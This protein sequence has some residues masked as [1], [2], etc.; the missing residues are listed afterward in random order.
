[1]TSQILR[2]KWS[3]SL[4]GFLLSF[5]LLT[6]S[7]QAF[8]QTPIYSRN[9]GGSWTTGTNWSLTGHGGG[10]CGCTPGASNDVLIGSDDIVVI[11]SG[12]T[13]TVNSITV[14]DD[15][16]TATLT[17]GNT[18]NTSITLTVGNFTI[19]AG[20]VVQV[21]GDN[22]ATHAVSITGNFVNN[23]TFNMIPATTDRANVTID[24]AATKT[25]SGTGTTT[26]NNFTIGAAGPDINVS[27]DLNINGILNWSGDGL[28]ILGT[29]GDVILGS[30]ATMTNFNSNR[31]IQLDGLGTNSESRLIK[32]STN[33]VNSWRILY[34]VGTNTGGYT[35][36]DFSSSTMAGGLTNNSTLSVKPL[37]NP[38]TQGQMRR[39]FKIVVAGNVAA[40]TLT[41][42]NFYY[43]TATDLSAGD[44]QANYNTTWFLSTAAGGWATVGGTAPGT[45]FFTAPGSAQSLTTGTYFYAIGNAAGFTN[46]W[47]SYQTGVWND[48]EIWTLDPSGTTFVNPTNTT[49]LSGDAVVILNGFTVT[50]NVSGLTLSSTTIQGGAI[51]DIATSTGHNLGNVSGSGLLRVKSSSLP[52]GTY[53]AFVAATGGTIEY[54]DVGGTLT[55]QATYNKLIFSNST[56]SDITYVTANNFSVN[57][58]MQIT[59]TGSGNVTWQIN[60]NNNTP[61][62]IVINGDLTVDA[63]GRI[64]AGTGNAGNNPHALTLKGN[65]TNNGIVKFFDPTDTDYQD[66]DYAA[67]TTWTQAIAGNTV[68]VTFSGV[69]NNTVSCNNTT[70][71]YRLIVNK[72]TGQ[73]AILTVNSTATAN[74]RLFAPNDLGSSGTAPNSYSNNSLS[75]INGTLQLTGNINITNMVQGGGSYPLPQNGCI[76]LNGSVTVQVTSN[77]TAGGGNSRMMIV[78]GRLRTSN[79]G[80]VFNSGYSRGLLGGQSGELIVEDGTINTYQFRTTNLGSGNNFT[81]TQSGGTV[82]VG[83]TGLTGE[84]VNDYPRFALPYSTTSFTMTNGTLN[85]GNPMV[86]GVSAGGGIMINSASSAINVTGGTV[87]VFLPNTATNFIICSNAPFYNFRVNKTGAGASVASIAAIAATDGTTINM[88]AQPLIVRNNLTLVSGNSPTL[89]CNN[90]NVTIGGHFEIQTGTTFTPGTNTLTFNGSADQTWTNSGTITSLNNVVMT[91]TGTLQMAGTGFP[92]MVGLALNSGTLHDGGNSWNVTSTISNSAVHSGTGILTVAG[93]TVMGGSNGTFGNLT[94]TTNGAVATSG[95]QTVTGDLRLQGGNSTLNISLYNLTVYGGI[96]SNSLTSVAFTATK[97]ILTNGARNDGGLTRSGVVGQTLLFP[98][99]TSAVSYSPMSVRIDAATTVGTITIRPVKTVHPN[100][101]TANQ[102]M[103]YFWRVNSTGF[104][105]LTGVSHRAY[106]YN[107]ATL[108][109]A[110]ANYRIARYDQTTFSWSYSNAS[111]DAAAVTVMPDFSTGTGWTGISSD[112]LDGEYTAGNTSAFG[113]VT[114]YYTRVASGNW[115]APATWS[116]T[117]INGPASSTAPCS[118]CPVVIGDATNN[119]TVLITADNQSCGSLSVATNSVLDCGTFTGLNFGTSAPIGGNGRIRI[120]SANFPGGDFINFLGVAGGTIEWYGPGYTIPSTGP[121]PASMSLSNYYNL[122][123]SP[124]GGSTILMPAT[125]LT[126]HNNLTISGASATAQ[127]NSNT[128]AA[129]SITVKNDFSVNS[130]VFTIRNGVIA[131]YVVNGNTTVAS[132]ASLSVQNGGATRTHTFTTPGNFTNNGTVLFRGGNEL[133][134]LTFTGTANT[135]LTGTNAG[136]ST[137]LNTVTVNKG[138]SQASTLTIDVAGTVSTLSNNWLTLTNG[139]VD[140]NRSGGTFVLTNTATNPYTIPATAKL[141]VRNGTVTVSNINNDNSDLLL[142]GAIEV[143]G[144]TLNIGAS[145]N[146]NN[147]DIEYASAGT[148]TITVSSGTLYVNGSIRRPVTT[149]AGALNYDQSGGDVTVGGRNANN[150]RGVFEIENSTGSDFTLTGT[151]TLSV[152][153]PTGGSLFTDLYLNPASNAVSST[154]TVY[155]GIAGTTQT[156]DINVV[157]SLGNLFV[158]NNTTASMQSSTLTTTGTLTINTNTA[159]LLTNS[160]DVTIGGDLSINGTGVYNGTVGSGNTTIFNGTGAQSATLSSGST[161]LNM[162][163]NKPSGTVSLSGTSPTITNLNILSGILDVNSLNLSVIGDIVNNSSQVNTGG[164]GSISLAGGAGVTAQS[165]TSNG[166]SFGNLTLTGSATAKTVTVSG[167]VTI[168]GTLNFATTNRILAVG[169]SLV[170]FGNASGVTG[171]GGTSFIR[172]NGVSSDLGVVKRWAVGTSTF[173]YPVGT[174]TNYTPVTMTLTVTTAGDMTVVPVD[175]RHPTANTGSLEQIL[176]YYWVI[177]RT[178]S[179]AYSTT[180]SHVYAFPSALMGGAGGTV[181]AGY[182]D[183]ASTTPGWITTGHGGTATTSSMTYTNLLNTNL[184][185][186]GNT[187]HYSVGT[188]NTL[189]NPIIPIYSRL[190]DASV[191]DVNAGGDWNNVN[192]WTLSSTG[193][194]PAWGQIPYGN[195]VVILPNSRINISTTGRISFITQVDGILVLPS[196]K[197][198]HNFGII[199]GTGTL[200]TNTSTL[201]A[202]NYTTFVSS[203]GGT[204]E[205]VGPLTMNNRSTYNNLSIIG[206]GNVTMTNTDLVLN[207]S[208]SVGSGATLNNTTNNRNISI[209]GN[210]TNLGTINIGTGTVSFTGGNAQTIAGTASFYNL[211]ISKSANNVTL[212]SPTTVTNNLTLTTGHIVASTAPLALGS[213]TISGGSASSYI[214][215]TVTK[216]IASGTQSMPLGSIT[217][218]RYRPA[219]IGNPSAAD[220]WTFEY[221]AADPTTGGYNSKTMDAANLAKV[222]GFEYWNISRTGGTVADLTLTYGPGSYIPPNIGVLSS[223]RVVKWNTGTSRWELATGVP[224]ANFV[225]TGDNISG[226]VRAPQVTSFSPHTF[227]STDPVSPLPIELI[228]FRAS[229]VQNHVEL[230][231]ETA[232]EKNNDYFTV[233]K[234]SNPETFESLVRVEGKGTTSTRSKY[235]AIDTNPYIGLSYYRLKQTDFDGNTSYSKP[236][237]IQ[238]EGPEFSTLEV[239]PNPAVSGE[240]FTVEVRGLHSETVLPIQV[241]NAQGQTLFIQNFEVKTKGYLKEVITLSKPLN[242]GIYLIKA[243]PYLPMI[244]KLVVE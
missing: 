227:G 7:E 145:G 61:L 240:S 184:P 221:V 27:N 49:P 98:V 37:Y 10:S 147:N 15:G 178:S 193:I 150:T 41:N 146:N 30:A 54:Y 71:F 119:H 179:L 100:V 222:S 72:G 23:G 64:T 13:V 52:S 97:R 21:G 8:S 120:A 231:W 60:N 228:Y 226:T 9:G 32:V 78:Y 122:Q 38:S 176:N 46:T 165:I 79:P 166:G 158:N 223:L 215:G 177:T 16:S 133:V 17:I 183:I 68:A 29:T 170:T 151:G 130:G 210:W 149:L 218:G 104:T 67:G 75:L 111:F 77:S 53:T 58:T 168:N 189:P 163:V 113:A 209:A 101:T 235:S 93:P 121:A 57:S 152:L 167:N 213:A 90:N 214:A 33:N 11:P 204:I 69:T 230:T 199:R 198:G 239:Y 106:R 219:S 26:F 169:S 242:S 132:G 117:G 174:R 91:K 35:P 197:V 22:N 84:D 4:P 45:T 186:L 73:Q 211:A 233:E 36:M 161:F 81:Y 175:D 217:P 95:D 216:L 241:I 89:Q 188:V 44:V 65:F 243:G 102:S 139:T 18:P 134:N 187:F 229:L 112:V 94:I 171:A 126:I 47:Y 83:T 2:M 138:T 153:R 234:A 135:S 114:A 19:N 220:T 212:A 200:R 88:A 190:S 92:N 201:P 142:A 74:F 70:D 55:S 76:W 225:V 148:P 173:V 40:T 34:P 159:T 196:N 20:G 206:S 202:G 154:S 136:A 141:M 115:D 56:G 62:A 25:F 3:F 5:I 162:T 96:Y 128:T 39:Q 181:L 123:I 87:N 131:T 116:N 182:L 155:L 194:G 14:N 107:T 28:I 205:Y 137:T 180:G 66:A 59:G 51:L 160:L 43:N 208:L 103:Q 143:A 236:Q 110:T 118:T 127:V 124:N 203:S 191:A 86:G 129:R 12:T 144:G 85:V 108:N 224:P 109:G 164:T 237:P 24:N 207:G 105:G 192:S 6:L 63:R 185:T 80:A 31:Y 50:S 1:M 244:K 195:S 82:N 172:T 125:D 48:P 238:Y 42:G 156:I 140:F 232:S 99:G 157:P